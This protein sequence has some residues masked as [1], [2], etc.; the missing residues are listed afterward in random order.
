MLIISLPSFLQFFITLGPTPW[1]DGKH[2]IF[3]R[4]CEGMGVIQRLG[5]VPVGT[6]D[7]PLSEVKI[8]KARVREIKLLQ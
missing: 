6:N 4:I 2:T 1:L 3:G 8:F 7:R 5:C